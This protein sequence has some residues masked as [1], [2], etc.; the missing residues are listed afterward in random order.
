MISQLPE[1]KASALNW[2]TCVELGA[3]P[4]ESELNDMFDKQLEE[5][6]AA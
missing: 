6:A 3:N 4:T 2:G 5:R 1:L